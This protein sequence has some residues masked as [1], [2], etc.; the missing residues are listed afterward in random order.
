MVT[1]G[2][3]VLNLEDEIVDATLLTHNGE[4]RHGPTAGAL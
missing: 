1:D 3:V 4:V 2:A